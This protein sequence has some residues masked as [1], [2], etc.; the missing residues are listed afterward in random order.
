MRDVLR[1]YEDAGD[2]AAHRESL[3]EIPDDR[4]RAGLGEGS[5]EVAGAARV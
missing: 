1:E 4:R 3:H 2:G 5:A